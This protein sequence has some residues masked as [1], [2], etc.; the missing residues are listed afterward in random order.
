MLPRERHYT[1]RQLAELWFSETNWKKF[2][3]TLRR[4]FLNEPGVINAGTNK[5]KHLLI[6][7]SVA[8]RVYRRRMIGVR[9]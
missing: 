1:I 4:W 6:P 8:E 5:N 7:E 9:P 3:H 2:Y